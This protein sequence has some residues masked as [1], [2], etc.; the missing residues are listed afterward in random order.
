MQVVESYKIAHNIALFIKS[1]LY[2][3]YIVIYTVN[4]IGMFYKNEMYIVI[5]M[6]CICMYM[7]Y[8]FYVFVYMQTQF[9]QI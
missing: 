7:F 9:E 6:Y 8:V 1:N 5:C 3:I 2:S 4:V